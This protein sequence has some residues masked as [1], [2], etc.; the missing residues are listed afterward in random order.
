MVAQGAG[1]GGVAGGVGEESFVADDD[2][3]LVHSFEAGQ[4]GFD[5]GGLDAEAAEFDLLVGASQEAD[6]A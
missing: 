2:D 5:L 4:G 1:V 3:G 6:G